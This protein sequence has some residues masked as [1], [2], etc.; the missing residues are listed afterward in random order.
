MPEQHGSGGIDD[1]AQAAA[2]RL[3]NDPG[4]CHRLGSERVT[5]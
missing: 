3:F 1:A 2:A 4:D 5:A